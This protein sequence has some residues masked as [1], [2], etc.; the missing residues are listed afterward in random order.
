MAKPTA[1]LKE[2]SGLV[3]AKFCGFKGSQSWNLSFLSVRR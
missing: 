2:R 1:A 3:A